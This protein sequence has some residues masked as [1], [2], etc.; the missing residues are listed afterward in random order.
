MPT[1]P[2]LPP[3]YRK[4]ELNPNTQFLELKSR[5]EPYVLIILDENGDPISDVAFG[6]ID[7]ETD[8]TLNVGFDSMGL[9][10]GQLRGAIAAYSG[11]DGAFRFSGVELEDGSFTTLAF[12]TAPLGPYPGFPHKLLAFAA[13]DGVEKTGTLTFYSEL[14]PG[15]TG[16][17][18]PTYSGLIGTV[19]FS[20]TYVAP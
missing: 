8:L 15:A 14:I 13:D 5:L 10:W 9:E 12:S 11:D 4:Q 3:N 6:D 1:N 19:S 20:K 16:E 17:D 18:P 7:A 2:W